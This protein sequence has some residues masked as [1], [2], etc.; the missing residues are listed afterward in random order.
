MAGPTNTQFAV[1]VHVLT[2]L[3]GVIDGRDVR[4]EELAAGANVNPVYVRRILGPLRAAGLVRARRGRRGGW[5][6]GVPAETITLD[7]VW[8]LIQ[9]DEP[10]LGLHGPDPECATGR[11]VQSGLIALDRVVSDSV[12][13]ALHTVTISDVASSEDPATLTGP[14]SGGRRQGPLELGVTERGLRP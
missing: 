7:Q 2:Y 14:S 3:A 4:S 1:A 8:K 6:L 10:V 11:R 9:R 5:Q 12:V 13:T